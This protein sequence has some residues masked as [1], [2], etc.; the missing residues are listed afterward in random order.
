[1]ASPSEGRPKESMINHI[2]EIHAVAIG[3]N[4]MQTN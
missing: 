2:V 1:M 4:A 3:H